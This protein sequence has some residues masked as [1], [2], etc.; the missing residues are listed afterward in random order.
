MTYP[1]SLTLPLIC[2]ALLLY[3]LIFTGRRYPHLPPG[4]PTLPIIGNLHQL[5][6]KGTYLT[7]TTWSKTYGGIFSRKF[8]SS[9]AIV[10]TSRRLVKAI[11]DKKSAIYMCT[12]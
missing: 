7:F 5:P 12:T 1:L 9:T 8:G 10:L 6:T 3:A 11:I 4:P 2:L